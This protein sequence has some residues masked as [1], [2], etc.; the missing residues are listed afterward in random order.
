[1]S[2]FKM[3]QAEVF[4]ALQPTPKQIE[5]FRA[6]VNYRRQRAFTEV[7]AVEDQPFSRRLLGGLLKQAHQTH[8]ASDGREA[9]NMYLT[10]APD[11]AFLDIE[12]PDI[13]GH[14]LAQLLKAIDPDAFIVMVTAN[15]YAEDVARAKEYGAR[16]FIIKPYCKE[17]IFEAIALFEHGT[18]SHDRSQL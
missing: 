7:L 12:L 17:K 1:M 2:D 18:K 10:Y 4:S 16:G 13:S 14:R 9:W 5:L 8:L 15:N 11:I 3:T 6:A